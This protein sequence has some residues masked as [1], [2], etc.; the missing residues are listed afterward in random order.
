MN[1]KRI[2]LGYISKEYKDVLLEALNQM[3]KRHNDNNY[4]DLAEPY[5]DSIEQL[6]KRNVGFETIAGHL[7]CVEYALKQYQTD[8]ITKKVIRQCIGILIEVDK[9]Q[10]SIIDSEIEE[11]EKNRLVLLFKEHL[12]ANYNTIPF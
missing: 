11:D 1:Y 9:F 2:N 7:E 3:V 5:K 4:P 6:N 12:S 8:D 10:N